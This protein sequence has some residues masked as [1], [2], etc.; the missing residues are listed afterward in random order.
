MNPQ[1]PKH[2]KVIEKLLAYISVYMCVPGASGAQK[3]VLDA[4]ELD[5]QA[6]MR[7]QVGVGN[8]TLVPPEEQEEQPVL[9]SA[10][11]QPPKG[12]ILIYRN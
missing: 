7:Q 12:V 6:V 11:L 1:L 2:Q 5:L 9:L 8:Q 4:L 10:E 3:R